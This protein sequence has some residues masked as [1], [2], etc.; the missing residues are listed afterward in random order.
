[1]YNLPVYQCHKKVGA[2][3]IIDVF[4]GVPGSTRIV[5]D[6][7]CIEDPSV[8]TFVNVD[9]DW[10]ARNPKVS[11]GGYFVEYEDGYTSF[12]PAEPFESGYTL[13]M[14]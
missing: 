10:L 8:G 14:P 12:S 5:L 13:V 11:I 1:M 3:K 6:T 7:P 9:A 4:A 2:A